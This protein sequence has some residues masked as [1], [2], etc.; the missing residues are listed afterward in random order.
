MSFQLQEIFIKSAAHL[1]PC[2][3]SC[4]ERIAS[5]QSK[6][7]NWEA[8]KGVMGLMANLYKLE[9][10]KKVFSEAPQL[11]N[12]KSYENNIALIKTEKLLYTALGNPKTK[13][14]LFKVILAK[15]DD[16]LGLSYDLAGNMV[17]N[18][19]E[20]EGTYLEYCKESLE[21]RDYIKKM[22]WVGNGGVIE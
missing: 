9:E 12:V 21:Q 6:L 4:D 3:A 22:C 7:D 1:A 16:L 13:K 15:Y 18:G 8:Y 10:D 2:I 17:L 19:I 20:L 5:V 11:D 14:G